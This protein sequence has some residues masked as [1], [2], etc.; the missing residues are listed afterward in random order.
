MPPH[1]APAHG[2]QITGYVGQL[3]PV[4]RMPQAQRRLPALLR[5][6]AGCAARQGQPR[7]TQDSGFQPACAPHAR[8][9]LQSP[10]G[11]D[12]LYLLHVRFPRRGGRRLA[13]RSVGDDPH[14]QRPALFLHHQAYRPPHAGIAARLGR[15]LRKPRRGLH[16]REPGDGRL[17]AAFA[18]GRPP[19][20]TSWSSAPRCSGRST[21]HDTSSPESKRFPSGANQATKPAPAITTGYFRSAANASRQTSPSFSTKPGHGLSRTGAFTASAARTSIRR[22]ARPGSTTRQSD[23]VSPP[24]PPCRRP[25]IRPLFSHIPLPALFTRPF[26]R[27]LPGRYGSGMR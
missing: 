2:T 5:L 25:G 1:G 7:G 22:P 4:A 3:E 19:C 26:P 8:R 21:S 18:A 15:R 23:E 10:A 20:A 6:P 11:R 24:Y 12:G 9:T 27:L 17:P 16:G 13:R 14:T